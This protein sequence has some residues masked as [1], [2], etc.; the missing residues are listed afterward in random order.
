MNRLLVI[1][2]WMLVAVV[3]AAV[4]AVMFGRVRWKR[5]TDQTLEALRRSGDAAPPADGG[6]RA[7][8]APT[9]YDPS[10]LDA[11]PAP[12]ARYFRTVL[13]PGQRFIQRA[14]IRHDGNFARTRNQ[15]KPFTSRQLYSTAP[16]GFVW[17]ASIQFLPLLPF[18][19]RDS[20]QDGAGRMVGTVAGVVTVV[21]QQGTPGM[22]EASLL[23]YL[24]EAAW[25]PTALLPSEGV[26]WTAVDDR[27]ARATLTDRNH[28]VTMEVYFGSGGEMARVSANRGREVNGTVELT[29]WEGHFSDTLHEVDGMRIPVSGEVLW[30]LPKGRHSY[31]RGLVAEATYEYR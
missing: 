19:V 24:A 6:A 18:R 11:L 27:T 7:P 16:R 22:G 10:Q 29:P 31:W 20:Y 8:A 2:M 28:T 9:H 1:S 15:W 12:V 21:N 4:V 30:V 25:F 23:R 3:V 26:Q 14:L 5:A 13:T 17:D